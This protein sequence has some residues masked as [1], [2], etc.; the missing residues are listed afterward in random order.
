M[1]LKVLGCSGGIG[2]GSHTTAMLLDDDI[3]IDAGT[4]VG[5]LAL[6]AL[7]KIDH[8]FITHSHLDHIASLPFLADT[9]AHLRDQPLIVHALPSTLES[10]QQHIFNWHIWPDFVHIPTVDH[11]YIRFEPLTVGET[12]ILGGR[13]ITPLPVC[14]AV[15]AVGFQLD[16]GDASLVFTGDTS[17]C[18]ELWAV[19]NQMANL[20]YLIIECAFSDVD[21][22]LAKRSGHMY[23]A[24][25]VRELNK[26]QHSA[27]IYITH[28]RQ[29]DA[30]SIM[31]EI[32]TADARFKSQRLVEDQVFEF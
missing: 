15:P 29:S 8:V 5:T 7:L 28:L 32:S 24:M 10:M 19:V 31:Q 1:R 3:L 16:S 18:D 30:E 12:V 11:P 4:G 25:L 9:S 20:R 2:N 6:D 23:P 17:G 26:L 21:S 22:D 27:E 14:H 13:R